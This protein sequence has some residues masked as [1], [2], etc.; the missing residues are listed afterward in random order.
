M[1]SEGKKLGLFFAILD[2]VT[3]CPC[4]SMVDRHIVGDFYDRDKIRSLAEETD[5]I[6]YEFEHIDADILMELEEEGHTIYPSPGT[7]KMIQDKFQQKSFLQSQG[8]PVSAFQRVKSVQDLQKSTLQY[9][10]PLL[11]KSCRGGYDGKGNY[12][13]KNAEEV[14]TAYDALGGS[15]SELMVEA[16]VPFVKEVSVIA[17]RGIKGEIK[18]YPLGENIHENNILKTTIIPAR[19]SKEVEEKA[20]ALAMETM[21]VLKGVG[22]FCI[23]MFV[24][25]NNHLLVNEIAP[26]PHNSGHY[27]IEAC[28][29]S[30]FAQHIR[31]IL[32]LPLGETALLKPAVMINLL[33]EKGYEGRAKLVGTEKALGLPKVYVHFYG[34]SVTA[35]ERKMGHITILDNNLPLALKK[36][37]RVKDMVK[38]IS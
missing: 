1:I 18:V 11:L 33:G 21:E 14:S 25:K 10:F 4:S 19:V 29:T 37:E 17:A 34:K 35:P 36:A 30:Q 22:I 20:K 7:L 5:V 13:I 28:S 24:D 9:G 12:V 38:V 16:F 3:D 15:A 2:P 27:T 31:A 23:E 26:R 8:I 32:G 6:T